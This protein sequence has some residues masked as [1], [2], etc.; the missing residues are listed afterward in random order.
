MAAAS[1]HASTRE[2]KCH[3]LVGSA[4]TLKIG[5]LFWGLGHLY[6]YGRLLFLLS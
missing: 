3:S 5:E 4:V 6:I 2:T 1:M